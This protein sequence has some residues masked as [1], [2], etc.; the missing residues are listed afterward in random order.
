MKSQAKAD[1]DAFC[2]ANLS[3]GKAESVSRLATGRTVASRWSVDRQPALVPEKGISK[4]YGR[5]YRFPSET[6]ASVQARQQ[7][8]KGWGP[9]QQGQAASSP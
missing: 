9:W 7:K 3:D 4:S 6:M 8:S 1:V 5:G 2:H